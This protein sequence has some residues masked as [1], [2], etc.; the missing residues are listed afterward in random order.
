MTETPLATVPLLALF[1]GIFATYLVGR[2]R[3]E[4]STQATG[5]VAVAS[6]LVA[7]GATWSLWTSSLP[8][9][10]AIGGAGVGI[11]V[12]ALGVFL[13]VV[14]CLAGLA[15][16]VYA[17]A[18]TDDDGATEL[19]YPLVLAA[20]AGVVGI[21]V[22]ADLFSLYVFFEV[23][24]VATY[25]LVPFAVSRASAVEA[26]FKYVVLNAVGSVLAIFGVS[27]VYAET[28]G[29]LAFG[30][31]A[32]ALSDT[33]EIATAAVLFLVVGFGVKAAIVPLHTWVP[34]AYAESPA[35]A[36]ALLAGLATPAAAVA[37]VKALSVFPGTVPVGLVLVVFGAIT[38]TVG[39]FL[40][41]GQR[42]LKRLLAYSSIPHVGYVIFGFGI[43]FYGDFG[44]AVD[45][46]LFHVLAN[47]FMKGGAFLAVGAIAYRLASTDVAN[48]RHLDDLA[49]IGYRMPVAAGA[50]AV[51]VLALAGVPPLAGFWGKLLI[52]VGGA[53]V[54]GWLGVALALLV[55]GNSFL[56]LG[57]Y[58]PVLRSL[59]ASPEDA[60]SS[61]ARTP[62]LLAIP[63]LGLTAGTILLGIVPSVGFDLVGPATDVLLSGVMP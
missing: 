43:G 6:L 47:A 4:R 32:A 58:L 31:V 13:S 11:Q 39:N 19:Y 28:G 37:M 52:V 45:G 41:L 50:I 12:T 5:V 34:D 27:L 30:P 29:T 63:I 9:E 20:V 1:A 40:A 38:M 7:L 57:Y 44:V 21:G 60:V 14:A 36:S 35:G 55:I 56:S 15:V 48:P 26:G 17:M 62:T 2:I 8:I 16:A 46:A 25:A 51:A 54:S 59:F 42:D 18:G 22:S 10:Y 24:A 53:E 33:T 61:A 49:G 23:M 3:H